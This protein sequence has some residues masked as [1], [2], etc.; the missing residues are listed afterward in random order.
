[1]LVSEV[2]T[3]TG[4]DVEETFLIPAPAKYYMQVVAA[5]SGS[6]QST[7]FCDDGEFVMDASAVNGGCLRINKWLPEEHCWAV[8]GWYVSSDYSTTTGTNKLWICD[9]T[10]LGNLPSCNQN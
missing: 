5:T 7:V 4:Q 1:M 3:G 2:Y 9:A 8:N 6:I 10:E